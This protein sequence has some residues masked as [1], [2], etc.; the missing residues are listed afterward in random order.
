MHILKLTQKNTLQIASLMNNGVSIGE[1]MDMVLSDMDSKK[2]RYFIWVDTR[3]MFVE[4]DKL[5]DLLAG[6][7]SFVG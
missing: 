6:A 4:E 2:T 5:K 3:W 1:L 7:M